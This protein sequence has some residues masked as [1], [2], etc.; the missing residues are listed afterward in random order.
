MDALDSKTGET[1]KF[2]LAT[3]Q[4]TLISNKATETGSDTG[5]MYI[6]PHMPSS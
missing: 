5:K 4:Y 3:L 6:N 2:A 1:V